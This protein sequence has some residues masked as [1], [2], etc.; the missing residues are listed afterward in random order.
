M[1]LLASL[2]F[3]ACGDESPEADAPWERP[4]SLPAPFATGEGS[5]S[6]VLDEDGCLDP[7]EDVVFETGEGIV[8]ELDDDTCFETIDGEVLT[9]PQVVRLGDAGGIDRQGRQSHLQA[10]L[11]ISLERLENEYLYLTEPVV[12]TL[13]VQTDDSPGNY[14]LV[15]Y[16][17]GEGRYAFGGTDEPR[18]EVTLGLVAVNPFGPESIEVRAGT[19]PVG[20]RYVESP[21]P[22]RA[23]KQ[24]GSC[25]DCTQY[26]LPLS[27]E[28]VDLAPYLC[29]WQFISPRTAE[30]LAAGY[31]ADGTA[32][33]GQV[34]SYGVY[35][36]EV[37]TDPN[38]EILA[39]GP[40]LNRL[41]VT[42][43]LCDE[44]GGE[45]I[46]FAP[47]NALGL[48]G[49]PDEREN[50]GVY[51]GLVWLYLA[52]R[53]DWEAA[54][55]AVRD[56]GADLGFQT[57][58]AR[59]R[60]FGPGFHAT[61]V[62]RNYGVSVRR[63]ERDLPS[64]WLLDPYDRE[65]YATLDLYFDFREGPQSWRTVNVDGRARYLSRSTGLMS[66]DGTDPEGADDDL[67][68]ASIELDFT[69]PADATTLEFDV[70]AH[71]REGADARYRVRVTPVG[72]A[73]QVLIDWTVKSG[74]EGSLTFDTV[75]TDLFAYAGQEVTLHLD[76]DA[77]GL[78]NEQI[79]YDNIWIH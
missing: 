74:I 43:T 63:L 28:Q 50:P 8:V 66:L 33:S 31:D 65:A 58:L 71:D 21:T 56:A 30:I 25:A 22:K 69:V 4:P 32:L 27:S 2:L 77:N 18:E 5:A 53:S 3:I 29:A 17:Q 52:G 44:D 55:Q 12:Y 46:S 41:F 51:D 68:N 36:I 38:P 79:Y 23:P 48:G 47:T 61:L 72:G 34:Q 37:T 20:I 6:I 73:E 49:S 67:P 26:R 39:Q 16:L 57:E 42:G 10:V 13:E 19:N 14:E 78:A 75:T 59:M 9:G 1:G 40:F 64:S 15:T 70:S 7:E 35:T 76:Q 54:L 24:S 11:Q 62:L 60:R 45:R